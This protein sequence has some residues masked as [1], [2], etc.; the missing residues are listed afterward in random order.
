[1]ELLLLLAQ[2][3]RMCTKPI[4]SGGSAPNSGVEV[5]LPVA[6]E[7]A[8]KHAALPCQEPLHL[9]SCTGHICKAMDT[10]MLHACGKCVH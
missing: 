6:A 5:K 8:A 7:A 10:V 3:P 4:S 1:M 2:P 9:F